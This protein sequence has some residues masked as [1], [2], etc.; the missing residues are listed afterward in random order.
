M[1]STYTCPICETTS[2]QVCARRRVDDTEFSI[3]R[4]RG[5]GLYGTTPLPEESREERSDRTT[6]KWF[7]DCQEEIALDATEQARAMELSGRRVAELERRVE[8]RRLL[9]MGTG[10][11]YIL[12]AAQQRGWEVRGIEPSRPAVEFARRRLGVEVHWGVWEDRP[13]PDERFSVVRFRHV[14][15]HLH[16][17]ARAL[18][19]ARGMMQPRGLL[20][21]EVPNA[22]AFIYKLCNLAYWLRGQ[23]AEKHACGVEPPHHLWGFAPGTLTQLLERAGL[24]VEELRATAMGDRLHYPVDRKLLSRRRQLDWLADRVGGRLGRGSLLVCYARQESGDRR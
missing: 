17:P 23:R 19:W 24:E 14:L 5:C 8:G 18:Q 13:F 6:G 15:E 20:A 4:C 10:K 22:A 9:D 7:P 11:A 2:A 21:L 12:A 1:P 3:V 16:D